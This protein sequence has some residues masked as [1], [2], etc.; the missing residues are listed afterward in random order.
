[1]S[2]SRLRLPASGVLHAG[3]VLI[4]REFCSQAF[5]MDILKALVCRAGSPTCGPPGYCGPLIGC[6][7]KGGTPDGAPRLQPR[8]PL[9]PVARAARFEHAFVVDA[10]QKPTVSFGLSNAAEKPSRSHCKAPVAHL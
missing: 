4:Y 8:C 9:G 6:S 10:V 7:L 2:N 1:M 3:S 5:R